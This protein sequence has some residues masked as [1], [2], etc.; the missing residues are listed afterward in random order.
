MGKKYNRFLTITLSSML[1]F[2][3][4][5]NTGSISVTEENSSHSTTAIVTTSTSQTEEVTKASDEVSAT[6]AAGTDSGN[7]DK[8]DEQ[9]SLDNKDEDNEENTEVNETKNSS[10]VV[11]DTAITSYSAPSGFYPNEFDLSI[12]VVDASGNEASLEDGTIVYTTDGSDP[13]SSETATEYTGPIH[14]YDRSKDENLLSAV[15]PVEFSGNY[16]SPNATKDGFSCMINAPGNSS[17]D[18]C[19]VVRSAVKKSDGTYSSSNRATYFIGTPETHIQG[20]NDSVKAMQAVS[21]AAPEYFENSGKL[22]V[23]SIQMDYNDLFDGEVGI[24]VKGN[25]FEKA[26]AEYLETAKVTDGETARSLDANYKGRGREWERAAGISIFEVNGDSCTEI[27]N[28]NCG[29][30]IQG[31]Y[32]RSDLIKGFRIVAR[33]DYGKKNFKYPFFGEAYKND[34]GETMDKFKTLVLRPGGNCAFTAKF[35]DVFWQSLLTDFDVE[36]QRSRPAIVYLNG[37]YWGLY[38]LQEDYNE[39]YMENLH[40]VIDKDVVIVK[41]DAEKYE[42]GYYIDEGILPEGETDEEFFVKD[43]KNAFNTYVTLEN[44]ADYEEFCK[45]VDPE[46]FRDYFAAELWFN[47]KWDWPGKNWSMWKVQT[48]E[49]GNEYADGR[50][51]L[52]FYDCEFGGVSGSGDARVNTIKD[53]NY[54][55]YGML[56]P[57]TDNIVVTAFIKLMSNEGFRKSFYDRLNYLTENNFEV[58][59]AKNR[60]ND[61]TSIYS[62]L[63]EQFF[64]RYPGTGSTKDAV[65]GGFASAKCIE[66]FLE[67]RG[68]NIQRMIDY[69]EN[70]IGSDAYKEKVEKE[71]LDKDKE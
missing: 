68:D 23:V 38:L 70:T 6:T 55:P 4:C 11:F 18:K 42:S 37:E 51:R 45:I 46:S 26:L 62:P 29:I 25:Q 54:K 28:Q 53:D 21:E 20:I 22:A 66:D 34:A 47:N 58:T 30:R 44:D 50:W 10:K 32:S 33:N 16:N 19:M 60:L 64:N 15:N 57:E 43:L 12:G 63:Y 2:T 40:G 49:S 31:N 41:G 59:N 27:I 24:Y 8:K 7:D 9:G 56:D 1:L 71:A 5:S 65:S 52:M 69:A 35:N 67:K 14:I 48:P 61:F 3:A 39:D 13:V 36:T 17:V